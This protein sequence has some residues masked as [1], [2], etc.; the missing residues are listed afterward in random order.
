MC[1]ICHMAKCPAECP[2]AEPEQMFTCDL[3]EEPIYKGDT[4]YKISYDVCICEECMENARR[5]AIP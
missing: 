1:E 4:Y 2:N 3:C 5:E